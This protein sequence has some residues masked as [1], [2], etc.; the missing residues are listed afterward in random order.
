[1]RNNSWKTAVTM[2]AA[3]GLAMPGQFALVTPA[4]G[5]QIPR[6]MWPSLCKQYA[7][8]GVT[9]ANDVGACVGISDAGQNYFVNGRGNFQGAV[10]TT[11]NYLL[12]IYPDYFYSQWDSYTECLA[13]DAGY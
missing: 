2:I 10:A 12:D 4:M 9:P 11:C 7:S 8:V 13:D 3:I 1:M 5:Q 6:N